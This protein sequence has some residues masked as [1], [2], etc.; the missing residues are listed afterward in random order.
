M[1][2]GA[3][4]RR[5]R[6]GPADTPGPREVLG[7]AA[8]GRV[9]FGHCPVCGQ[10]TLF[11]KRRPWLRDYY[12]CL[13]CGSIPRQ[14]ALLHNIERFF[15]QWRGLEI[16]ES[17]PD[18]PASRVIAEQCRAYTASQYWPDVAAGAHK[19]G[20]RCE[21]LESLTFQDE[22]FD[23][24]ITQ[25]VFEHVLNPDAAFR[26]VARVLRPQGAHVFTVP[27]YAERATRMRARP[28]PDGIEYLLE[29]DYHDNPI[30]PNGALVVTE[31]G[32]D[33]MARIA[34]VS[35]LNTI[36]YEVRDTKLGLD[37]EF[38]EVL[39]S[40]KPGG[41]WPENQSAIEPQPRGSSLETAYI[42]RSEPR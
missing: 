19:D 13:L 18:G 23:L 34:R 14:R 36:V 25:D 38:L 1:L 12:A 42:Q 21:N 10:S 16:Y 7:L 2:L 29:P 30:D 33:L 31:W 20:I 32:S 37:G 9:N 41:S 24:V 22:S 28:A 17:S 6:N 3:I 26:E 40:R 35:G 4:I 15:P 8:R 27:L 39:I 11:L 5:L